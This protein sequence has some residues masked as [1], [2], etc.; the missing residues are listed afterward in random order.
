M[1][2]VC[3]WDDAAKLQWLRVRLTE[4]ASSAFRG[5]P[6][7]TRGSYTR[8][9]DALRER[10]EPDSKRELYKASL[11]SY[12]DKESRG[13]LGSLWRGPQAVGR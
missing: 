13:R 3:N 1:A 6:E 11:N 10:F 12:K 7:G 8:A 9:V 2:A 4:R 5:L